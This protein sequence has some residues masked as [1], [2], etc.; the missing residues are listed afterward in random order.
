MRKLSKTAL[1]TALGLFCANSSSFAEAR[2]R[3]H[4]SGHR[5]RGHLVQLHQRHLSA[6]MGRD[7][8]GTASVYAERFRGRRTADGTRFNPALDTA[9]SK[10]LPLGTTARVTNLQT[11]KAATVH[12]RDRG[13]YRANRIIDVSPGTAAKLGMDRNGTAPVAVAPISPAGGQAR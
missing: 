2:A 12:V 10:T 8:K 13:P 7:Q 5:D 6:R 1:A 3:H 4:T 9:A 11:G